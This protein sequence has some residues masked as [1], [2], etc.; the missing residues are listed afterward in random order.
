MPG[1]E[2]D[3]ALDRQ[4]SGVIRDVCYPTT[5]VILLCST[6]FPFFYSGVSLQGLRTH[7]L[8]K[9]GDNR[10]KEKYL[11]RSMASRS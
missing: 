5:A 4:A 3:I 10:G 11:D 6:S 9:S 7:D 8:S 1:F 2:N